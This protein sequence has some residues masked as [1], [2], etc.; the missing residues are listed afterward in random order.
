[1]RKAYNINKLLD[2]SLLKK[3]KYNKLKVINCEICNSSDVSI[4]QSVGRIGSNFR[5][6][7]LPVS[8]CKN[9]GYTFLSPRLP[10]KF[11]K[12]YYKINYRKKNNNNITLDK[13]YMDS[14]IDRGAKIFKYFSNKINTDKKLFLDHGCASGLTMLEWRS[15]GWDCTGIDPHLPSV[16]Y[17]KKK[18]KLKL[19][20]LDGENLFKLN[21]KYNVI[22]SLG[23]L[24]HSYDLNLSLKNIYKALNKNGYLLIRWRSD[25]MIGSPLEYF[26]HNHFR[27]F[28]RETWRLA[29]TKHDFRILKYIKKRIEGSDGYEYIIA[30]K[31][32]KQRKKPI[33]LKKNFIKYSIKYKNYLTKYTELAKKTLMCKNKKKQL[34]FITKNKIGLL[35]IKKEK[36]VKRFFGEARNYLKFIND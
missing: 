12:A 3:K 25:R 35:S 15:Y 31:T 16:I 36:A 1:M 5:Y 32:I 20:N 30:K 28:N 8:I 24:E 18:F 6:G 14:Q 19:Y 13:E 17:G 2:K 26:N 9:C 4:L 22:L 33:V 11:Y 21:S 7:F 10:N 29:L 34:E 23:S 27:Y